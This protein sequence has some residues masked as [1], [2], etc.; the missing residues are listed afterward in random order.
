MF[1]V[2]PPIFTVNA[3]LPKPTVGLKV[4]T[5]ILLGELYRPAKAALLVTGASI[6]LEGVKSA[7]IV[8][9]QVEL[10]FVTAIPRVMPP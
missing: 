6:S 1:A 7:V 8:L 3:E 2:L 9:E 10:I 4:V 5:T